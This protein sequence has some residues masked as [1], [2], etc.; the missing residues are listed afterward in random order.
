MKKYLRHFK[1]I[2]AHKWHVMKAC[3]KVGLYWQGITHDLSKHSPIEFFTSARYFQGNKSPIDAEKIEN[4]YSLAWQNHKARNKHHWHYWT[5]F[6]NGELVII[7]MPA[8]YVAEMLCDWVGAG[9]AYNKSAWTIK[10]F[11]NWYAQ[12]RDIYHL[13]TST[14]AYIDMLMKH[15]ID[16]KD[17]YDN[18]ISVKRIQSNYTQ[19]LCEGCAYQQRYKLV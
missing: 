5:D 3:F 15:V 16:E 2:T 14:R 11:K 4:G 8:K 17:L 7:K 1:T 13:Y 6:E 12:N 18:W 19:D 10:S 9:K